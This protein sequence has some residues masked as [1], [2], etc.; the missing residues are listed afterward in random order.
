M[1]F[2]I[3]AQLPARL[4][5]RLAELGHDAIHTIS[6]PEGNRT[7]DRQVAA[8]ADRGLRIVVTK[9]SDFRNSHLLTGSP[10]RVLIVT[11]GNIGNDE[12][13]GLIETRLP[14]ISE[15]FAQ[16]DRVEIRRDAIVSYLRARDIYGRD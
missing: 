10:N 6:L 4:A 11:T 2:L 13:L 9:D 7:T 12:L 3:D 5:V 8:L 1:K 15:A 16:A 14:E